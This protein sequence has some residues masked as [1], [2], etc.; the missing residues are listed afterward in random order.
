VLE[1]V[2]KEW[3]NEV[4]TETIKRILKRLSM[5]W[6]RM[7]RGVGG[8]PNPIEYKEKQAQLEEF[9]RLEAAEKN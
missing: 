5:T 4:N 8:E 7:R 1:K 9:K 2:K 6:H 3:E